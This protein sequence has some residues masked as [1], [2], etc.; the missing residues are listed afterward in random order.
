MTMENELTQEEKI[1]A[2]AQWPREA[3][4]LNATQWRAV[5]AA[6]AAVLAHERAQRSAELTQEQIINALL[7]RLNNRLVDIK[8]GWNDSL[9]GFNDA[10]NIVQDAL[11]NP[12]LARRAAPAEPPAS[13]PAQENEALVDELWQKWSHWS[14]II[15]LFTMNL[16]EFRAALA[17][18][19]AESEREVK[20]LKAENH[21][22]HT[23]A[24]Q[25]H[26]N[27]LLFA[28]GG[29][30][31]T[32]EW[33]KEYARVFELAEVNA[34][35]RVEVE[36]LKAQIPAERV[37]SRLMGLEDGAQAFGADNFEKLEA[38]LA[39]LRARCERME[40]PVS[41]E[42]V[43]LL[44]FDDP[45]REDEVFM[46]AGATHAALERYRTALYS[47]NCHLFFEL[48]ARA[49]IEGAEEGTR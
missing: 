47:W 19:L 42:G 43:W 48:P 26:S 4:P 32:E 2:E 45:E 44:R 23:F 5:Y 21:T 9:E 27:W 49:A 11:T 37:L 16:A 29:K 41:E 31:S 39:T 14:E 1:I 13:A 30:W 34:A 12:I 7:I 35:L 15:S 3:L 24:A 6:C 46:G 18:V 38:E 36:R 17:A 33:K 28:N 22:V 10:M 25:W 40:A 8:P 20:E